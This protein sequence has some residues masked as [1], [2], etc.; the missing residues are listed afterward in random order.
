M[1]CGEYDI[2]TTTG[3]EKPFQERDAKNISIHPLYND[4]GA[5]KNLHYNYALIHTKENFE[6]DEE[7]I[8]PICLP[9]QFQAIQE[10]NNDECFAMGY[11]KDKFGN[12]VIHNISTLCFL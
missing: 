11:G 3:E 9:D 10:Y 6:L 1:R 12:S 8:Y 5:V 4:G 7:H 2:T